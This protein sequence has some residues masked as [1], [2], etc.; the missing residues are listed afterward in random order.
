MRVA[1]VVASLLAAAATASAQLPSIPLEVDFCSAGN[2]DAKFH[3]FSRQF[4][5]PQIVVRTLLCTNAFDPYGLHWE[6]A[7]GASESATNLIHV[8]GVSSHSNVTF[9]IL[10]NTFARAVDNWYCAFTASTNGG[11]VTYAAGAITV[12]RAPE[13]FA[14][15]TLLGAPS[16]TGPVNWNG[17]YP[18]YGTWP[19]YSANTNTLNIYGSSSGAYFTLSFPADLSGLNAAVN[20]MSN[21][22][23][24]LFLTRLLATSTYATASSLGDFRSSETNARIGADASLSGL[25]AS[26]QTS[27]SSMTGTLATASSNASM[28]ASYGDHRTNGYIKASSTNSYLS[29]GMWPRF[30]NTNDDFAGGGGQPGI[31][32]VDTGSDFPIMQLY[33]GSGV[34]TANV[35]VA[36]G[37]LA[38]VDSDG[39]SA[40]TYWN[41]RTNG[42]NKW[43]GTLHTLNANIGTNSPSAGVWNA[44]AINGS[45]VSTTKQVGSFLVYGLGGNS[46]AGR[47]LTGH[48]YSTGFTASNIIINISSGVVTRGML[49][50]SSVDAAYATY[51]EFSN[52]LSLM[53]LNVGTMSGRLD[54]A[55]LRSEQISNL[56]ALSSNAYYSAQSSG[57]NALTA[58]AISSNAWPMKGVSGMTDGG[59]LLVGYPTNSKFRA[60]IWQDIAMYPQASIG[61]DPLLELMNDNISLY[62]Q[63]RGTIKFRS[64]VVSSSAIA[65]ETVLSQQTNLVVTGAGMSGNINASRLGG[66]ELSAVLNAANH[67]NFPAS[68]VT[69]SAA[70]TNFARYTTTVPTGST[71]SAQVGQWSIGTNTSTSIWMYVVSPLDTQWYRQG[72]NKF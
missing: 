35:G 62:G 17:L 1:A 59:L 56:W 52:R 6:M 15:A 63:S 30:G 2:K 11:V 51:P 26:A 38:E 36:L 54:V 71:A 12:E 44:N 9:Q 72:F 49:D 40:R 7:F 53:D 66:H 37:R 68:L 24:T 34:T 42:F 61:Q 60:H 20:A 64:T 10:S 3:I 33:E 45:S 16:G 65:S 47:Y 69:W 23:D 21:W 5:T 18:F 70:I 46:V 50:T 22:V 19:L 14:G 41:D 57:S 25:V 48:V 31:R 28:A 13:I 43:T 29:M 58:M 4:N 55:F 8:Q 27:I 67:S 39:Q 32:F